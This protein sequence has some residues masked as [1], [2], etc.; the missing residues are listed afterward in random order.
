L[1]KD[2]FAEIAFMYKL[3][4]RS[5]VSY[6]VLKLILLEN[7]EKYAIRGETLIS[8]NNEKYGGKKEID[9]SFNNAPQEFLNFANELW[10]KNVLEKY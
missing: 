3:G 10:D 7:G 2:S 9:K 8:L 1:D 4:C 6:D 5:D